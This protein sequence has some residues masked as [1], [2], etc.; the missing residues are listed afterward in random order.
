M[1]K[2]LTAILIAALLCLASA[3][4][5]S[6]AEE[7]KGISLK[8]F[9]T[10]M[11]VGE[12]LDLEPTVTG[13]DECTVMITNNNTDVVSVSK[14][15]VV[16][17][18]SEGEALIKFKIVDTKYGAQCTIIVRE[19]E[20]NASSSVSGPVI[21]DPAAFFGTEVSESGSISSKKGKG[22]FY[23]VSLDSDTDKDGIAEYKKLLS[24]KYDFDICSTDEEDFSFEG[25]TYTQRALVYNGD[26]DIT[27][28]TMKIKNGMHSD[29][30]IGINYY[31]S[32]RI[33][34][35]VYYSTDITLCDMGDRASYVTDKTLRSSDGK[36]SSTSGGSDDTYKSDNSWRRG[37]GVTVK[38]IK[39]HGEGKIT[40]PRCNGDGTV[41][42]YSSPTPNYSGRRGG[43]K[44]GTSSSLC[45]KCKGSGEVDCTRCH[46]S[47]TM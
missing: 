32:G 27:D 39:C 43:A 13:F 37:S 33:G 22:R 36:E 4:N 12:T 42:S 6:A 5:V 18:L 15:G 41:E 2:R 14:Y 3:I 8:W 23:S 25:S 21:P 44:T 16:T 31:S 46:G 40:C 10:F 11:Y 20:E 24:E 34:L 9:K 26:E 35:S 29:G 38:C 17:A 28:I 19:K 1:M 47:G 30:F 45:S 7:K